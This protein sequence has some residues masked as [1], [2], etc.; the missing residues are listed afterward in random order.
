M[1]FTVQKL[2]KLVDYYTAI[3]H[4]QNLKGLLIKILHPR[5]TPEYYDKTTHTFQI[6][7][8]KFQKMVRENSETFNSFLVPK[9][10]WFASIGRK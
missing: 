2:L 7:I 1:D 3:T 10:I 4:S 5:E 6:K 9:C 8:E